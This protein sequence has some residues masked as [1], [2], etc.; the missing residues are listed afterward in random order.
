MGCAPL[1]T[2]KKVKKKAS[3]HLKLFFMMKQDF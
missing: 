1:Y 2:S 3:L